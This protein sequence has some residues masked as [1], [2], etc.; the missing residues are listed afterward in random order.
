M[1][2]QLTKL[3]LI[4]LLICLFS[5]FAYAQEPSG[6][7]KKAEGKSQKELLKQLCEIV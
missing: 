7:Y 1:N 4:A 6:Y 5:G 3:S 2:R